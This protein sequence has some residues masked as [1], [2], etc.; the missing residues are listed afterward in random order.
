MEIDAALFVETVY[1]PD[2]L[3]GT[4]HGEEPQFRAGAAVYLPT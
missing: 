2:R 3:T 1:S 4:T